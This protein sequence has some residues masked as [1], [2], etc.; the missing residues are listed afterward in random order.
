MA[1]TSGKG[2]A[3]ASCCC[4]G[5]GSLLAGG[6]VVLLYWASFQ[7]HR[8]RAAVDSATLFNLTVVAAAA[9]ANAS[10]A[11]AAALVSYRLAVNLTLYNPSVRVNI[12]YDT[13]YGELRFRG[14]VL[15]G[16][17]PA[18]PS[19]FN[20]RRKTGDE[21][22]LEFDRRGGVAVAADV[23][24][25]LEKEAKGE[26]RVSLE[27]DVDARV[28]YVFSIF[29]LRQKPKIRCSLSIPV[30]AAAGRGGVGGA[31]A[32]GDRCRVKY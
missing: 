20:Q 32:S 15:G 11:A 21:V 16:G 27:L 5:C 28:R 2:G 10:S 19:E 29:K 18:S 8:I 25:E 4:G 23:A 12:Y 24:G 13:V 7:P 31:L 17:A 22:E 14:A 9:N 6:I 30:R 3:G 1:S 26:G